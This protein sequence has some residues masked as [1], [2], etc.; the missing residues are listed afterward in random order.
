MMRNIIYL[1]VLCSGFLAGC[2]QEYPFYSEEMMPYLNFI[3]AKDRFGQVTD[4][5]VN[6]T[7]VYSG[8]AVKDD[9]VW[10]EVKHI[11]HIPATD[12]HFTLKQVEEAEGEQ[13]VPGVHY[14]ALDAPEVAARCVMKAGE[15]TA[16]VPLILL[17]D[18]SLQQQD[19]RLRVAVVDGGDYLA[20]VDGQIEKL[21]VLSDRLVQPEHWDRYIDAFVYGPWSRKKHE[22]LIET[23]RDK[24]IDDEYFKNLLE[25]PDMAYYAYLNSWIK[26]KLAEY[27]ADPNHTD[28]PLRDENGGLL[29]FNTQLPN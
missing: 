18:A 6:Y 13:A 5:V 10:L 23:I 16:K 21:F 1:I 25:T 17:R 26:I 9:T 12:L 20:G 8:Q 7:F 4:S 24:Q 2:K 14:V 11:G 22:F 28:A 19:V 15:I 29:N 27:N 3:Y